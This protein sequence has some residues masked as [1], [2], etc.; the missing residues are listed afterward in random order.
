MRTFTTHRA[1]GA[2]FAA[3]L[4]TAGLAAAVSPAH[5]DPLIPGVTGCAAPGG[6]QAGG[7]MLGAVAGGL[8][9]NSV[10]GHNRTTGTL[11]GAAVG[12][13][14]GSAVGCQIQHNEEDRAA[15]ANDQVEAPRDYRRDGPPLSR[16]VA[17]A[18]YKRLDSAMFATKTV[19]L[20]AAPDQDSRRVGKLH[21]GERF[22]AL[23]QVRD[24]DWIL[25]GRDGVGVGYVQGYYTRTDS[26][27]YASY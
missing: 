21:R 6:K 16:G 2:A 8:L 12:A 5:A 3:L 7:A 25:V 19:N 26:D 10:S 15:A 13:A 23:A 17:P 1:A 27:R 18:S 14:A 24:T 11:V 9:G 4:T 20:R 22:E